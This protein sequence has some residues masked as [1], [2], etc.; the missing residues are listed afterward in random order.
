MEIKWRQFDQ[1]RLTKEAIYDKLPYTSIATPSA[2]DLD[3]C[4]SIC[5]TVNWCN[6][7]SYNS[8]GMS[9]NQCLMLQFEG[10][11]DVVS[12]GISGVEGDGVILK[13]DNIVQD[14][15]DPSCEA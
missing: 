11:I 8:Q 1:Y 4:L 15:D 12:D 9:Y 3:E 2:R 13:C 7:V 14:Y 5:K 10:K 6:A